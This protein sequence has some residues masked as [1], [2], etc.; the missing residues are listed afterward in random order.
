MTH[1]FQNDRLLYPYKVAE[2]L[3]CSKRYVYALIAEGKIKSIKIG[4]NSQRVPESSVIR[5]LQEINA[6]S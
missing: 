6:N 1:D 2:M 5:F 3:C 4:P